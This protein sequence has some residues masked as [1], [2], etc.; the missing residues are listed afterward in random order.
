MGVEIKVNDEAVNLDTNEIET[1]SGLMEKMATEVLAAEEIVTAVHLNGEQ[2]NDESLMSSG[3]IPLSEIN[4]ISIK[5]EKDPKE[6]AVKLLTQTSDYLSQLS[7]GLCEVADTLRTGN[8]EQANSMLVQALD[9]LMLFTE[10]VST[11]KNLE[12]FDESSVKLEG[13]NISSLENRLTEILKNIQAGQESEDW[14]TV[15]DLLEYE[16]AVILREWMDIIPAI[17]RGFTAENS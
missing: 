4:A 10:L 1:F 9:G 8:V 6:F 7:P 12:G 17:Q 3:E 11:V 16:L 13:E 15:A 2:L 14:V 5:T